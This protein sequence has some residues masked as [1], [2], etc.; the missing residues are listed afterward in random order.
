MMSS[1][2]TQRVCSLRMMF[3]ASHPEIVFSAPST[4]RSHRFPGELNYWYLFTA[5]DLHVSASLL[6]RGD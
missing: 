6:G 4:D 5:S 3:M 2:A 1:L